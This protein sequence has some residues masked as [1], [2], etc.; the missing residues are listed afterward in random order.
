MAQE[1]KPGAAASG[2]RDSPEFNLIDAIRGRLAERGALGA[3]DATGRLRVGPGDDAAVTVPGGATAT[4]VDA[5]VDGVHF[6]SSWCPPMSVG[7]KAMAT[8]LSDL[9]AMGA[10]PG[11]AYVWLGRPEW[12]GEEDVLDLCEGLAVVAE[13]EDV[14]VAGGDITAA[15][16]LAVSVTAVGH[17]AEPDDFVRRDGAQP[18]DVLCVTGPLGGSAAGLMVLEHPDLTDRISAAADVAVSQCQLDPRPRLAAGRALAAGGVSAMVD[19]SDGLGADA[20]QLAAASEVAIEVELA[21]VPTAEGLAEVAEAAGRDA[22]EILIGGEDYELLAAVPRSALEGAAAAVAEAGGTL[23]EI[24]R[25]ERG[26]GVR[27]RLPGGRSLP[28][29]GYDQLR[30]S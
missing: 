2:M 9:A 25:V 29:G 11:E 4:T 18:G 1:P 13:R 27:L 24:G 17:A 30:S 10:E 20:E 3:A 23:A 19:I 12:L 15:G 5:V 26:R 6:R 14:V 8:A 28:P 22:F 21:R 7:R 16:E